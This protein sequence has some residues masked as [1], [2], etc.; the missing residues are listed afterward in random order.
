MKASDLILIL[1]NNPDAEI[2]VSTTQ[3][4]EWSY[5]DA[6]YKRT[7]YQTATS[8]TLDLE[9]NQIKLNGGEEKRI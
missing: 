5:Q 8:F 7:S 6:G 1:Q 3:Y 2:L 4:Y 9:E